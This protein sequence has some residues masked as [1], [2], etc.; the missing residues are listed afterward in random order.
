MFTRKTKDDLD[1]FKALSVG[2]WIRA[3]GRIEEDSFCQRFS[4]DDV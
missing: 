1:H 3:Q 2:K 4:Y